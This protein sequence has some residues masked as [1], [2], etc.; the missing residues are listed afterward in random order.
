MPSAY[1]MD[2][3]LHCT[4]KHSEP[5]SSVAVS[6]PTHQLRRDAYD[7]A[8]DRHR[9]A[10]RIATDCGA[11][12]NAESG[13]DTDLPSSDG[14]DDATRDEPELH[15]QLPATSSAASPSIYEYCQP[16]EY[17]ATSS[18]TISPAQAQLRPQRGLRLAAQRE[19]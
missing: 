7:A 8:R 10:C 4:G 17:A 19:A 2:T 14:D 3:L 6:S 11:D 15:M 5:F 13:G 12:L 16:R 1:E 18:A 9:D